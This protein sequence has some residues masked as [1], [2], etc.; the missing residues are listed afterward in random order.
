MWASWGGG[1]KRAF[2]MLSSN[3]DHNLIINGTHYHNFITFFNS[4]FH[5]SQNFILHDYILKYMCKS[6][7]TFS[8]VK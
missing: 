6:D 8:M 2:A 7:L 4:S 1:L 5:F 3:F